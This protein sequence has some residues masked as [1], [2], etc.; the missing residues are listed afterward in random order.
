[1]G[2]VTISHGH[3]SSSAGIWSTG[4]VEFS[5]NP[6]ANLHATVEIGD[7]LI[8]LRCL[9]S[10]VCPEILGEEVGFL[11][12]RHEDVRVRPKVL[13]KSR[14]P[15]FRGAR[16]EEVRLHSYDELSAT[17]LVRRN[18]VATPQHEWRLFQRSGTLPRYLRRY[19]SCSLDGDA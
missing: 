5:L 1:M 16:D 2:S 7:F 18:S 4:T 17:L 13:I 11:H 3:L 8:F 15:T 14:R 9:D 6:V 12:L 19:E 10:R